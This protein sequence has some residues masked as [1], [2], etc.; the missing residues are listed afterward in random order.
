[1]RKMALL[2]LVFTLCTVTGRVSHNK[3]V[4]T[5]CDFFAGYAAAILCPFKDDKPKEDA[6]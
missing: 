4:E 5:A 1:M 6:R 3:H 2:G